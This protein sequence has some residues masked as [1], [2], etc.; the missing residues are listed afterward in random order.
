MPR[1]TREIRQA[2]RE[3]V[4]EGRMSRPSID[5]ICA[6]LM[7]FSDVTAACEYDCYVE[8]DG[9]CEHGRPS[10]LILAGMV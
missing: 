1:V 8:P 6:M 10:W 7:D 5:D 3:D 9:W 4:R 2:I